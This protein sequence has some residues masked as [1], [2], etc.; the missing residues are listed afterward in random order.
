MPCV[1]RKLLA[2]ALV[3]FTT[4]LP[5]VSFASSTSCECFCGKEGV[6]AVDEKSSTPDACV[7]KCTEKSYQYVG[8]FTDQADY[9]L[10]SDKCWTQ[11]EC[12][13]WSDNR[14]GA[15]ITADWGATQPYDCGVT[16]TAGDPMHY[17]YAKDTPY[18]LNVTIGSTTEVGNL[19]TYINALYAWLLPAASLVAVVMM[20]I[21]GLQYVMARGKSKYIDAAKTR[22]TNAITGLV[23]L[24]S[25]FVLLNLVDPRFTRFQSLQVPLIKQVVL[26]DPTSS[27]ER[28]ADYG[29]TIGPATTSPAD[30][31][32]ACG[33]KGEIKD[34]SGLK[35]N[36]LGS[37]KV[38]DICDYFTCKTSGTTCIANSEIGANYCA[39][40]ASNPTPTESTC[41]MFER[42]NAMVPGE[43][44]YTYCRYDP[45]GSHPTTSN[46]IA[47][48][49]CYGVQNQGTGL[50][51]QYLNCAKA[52]ADAAYNFV[53]TD[54]P[55]HPGC[56]YYETLEITNLIHNEDINTEYY[57]SLLEEL[58]TDDPCGLA[59]DNGASHCQYNTGADVND[60]F[61]GLYTSVSPGF[62]CRTIGP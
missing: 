2:L 53:E 52:R 46:P 13:Q 28:L 12:S 31:S 9:P 39:A 51:E 15:N 17:C 23:L 4:F 34:D 56:S 36:A 7:A 62:Y 16:K 57:A 41:S 26:L 3:T 11:T 50:S 59:A 8:C 47:P 40:C 19:P 21:G 27:C 38:G 5:K 48:G 25:A 18:N 54:G 42:S 43:D 33:G 60:Y 24:L 37:W 30:S 6:G 29:Y 45:E 44:Q 49:E 32:A 14:G 10:E 55:D 1:K 35:D 22:I 61:F 58:C 20:M